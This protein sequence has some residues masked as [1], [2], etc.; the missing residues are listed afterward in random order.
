[1]ELQTGLNVH[2]FAECSLC[3]RIEGEER[4]IAMKNCNTSGIE[5]HLEKSNEDIFKQ[6]YSVHQNFSKSKVNVYSKL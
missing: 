6:I 5:R 2:K 1:M 4:I 3:Q